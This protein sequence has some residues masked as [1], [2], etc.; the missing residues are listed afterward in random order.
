VSGFAWGVIYDVAAQ[1]NIADR[2]MG[3]SVDLSREHRVGTRDGGPDLGVLS[4]R[5]AGRIVK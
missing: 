4:N 1:G 3:L 2:N 5:Q